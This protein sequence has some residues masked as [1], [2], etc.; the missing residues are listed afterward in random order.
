MEEVIKDNSLIKRSPGGRF[1][2]FAVITLF[3]VILFSLIW[4][5]AAPNFLKYKTAV[6]Y[7]TSEWKYSKLYSEIRKTHATMAIV[8]TSLTDSLA[9]NCFSTPEVMNLG[10][11]SGSPA[12]GLRVL[13]SQPAIPKIVLVETNYWN[14]S[15]DQ[16]IVDAAN[17]S[18]WTRTL[19]GEIKPL[20]FLI[21]PPYFRFL[22]QELEA[23]FPQAYF[24]NRKSLLAL[25]VEDYNNADAVLQAAEESDKKIKAMSPS[26]DEDWTYLKGLVS[27]I[28]QKGS[29][30][31]L[32]HMPVAPAHERSKYYALL[33]K[34]SHAANPPICE[35]CI[36]LKPEL[37][38]DELRWP[39]GV[40]LDPRSRIFV[41][42]ALE[43]MFL[44]KQ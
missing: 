30:V 5:F 23:P 3:I 20:R 13:L 21:T 38:M 6:N 39:D 8:G 34:Y 4:T 14:G 27:S 1:F 12:T 41:C 16:A 10:F 40:H 7:T 33:D 15:G 42:R 26:L 17:H 2:L 35:N 19:M 36:N 29:K 25:P 44:K 28:E 11:R 43:K 31:Y 37:P 18:N 24:E 22:H 9:D 32:L